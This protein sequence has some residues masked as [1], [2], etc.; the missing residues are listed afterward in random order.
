MR[1]IMAAMIAAIALT[2]SVQAQSNSEKIEAFISE[3]PRDKWG[4]AIYWLE[5]KSTIGW[6]NVMLVVGYAFNEPVC[7]KLAEVA[8]VDAPHREFRCST[9][10]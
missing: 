10:N 6:E 5:M 9:A 8:R 2:T 3:L 7:E 4:G 1:K